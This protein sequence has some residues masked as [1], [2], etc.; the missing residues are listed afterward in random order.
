MRQ[1][2]QSHA[3]MVNE[4]TMFKSYSHVF[5]KADILNDKSNMLHNSY[6]DLGNHPQEKQ[7]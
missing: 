2:K 3:H 5:N 6:G 1:R 4:L 7:S